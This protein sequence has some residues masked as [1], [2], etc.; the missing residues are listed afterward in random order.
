[1][2]ILLDTHILLWTLSDPDKLSDEMKEIISNP[3]NDIY[4]SS[5][6]PWEVEI[7]HLAKPEKMKLDS[8]KLINACDKAGFMH[9]NIGLSHIQTLHLLKQ[10]ERNI[11]HKDPFDKMLIAQAKSEGML[12]LTE[13]QKIK[14]YNEDCIWK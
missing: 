6:S 11:D 12:L 14:T 5:V 3:L 13:D 2:K 9:L 1:M 7:K 10:N 4:F 8:N